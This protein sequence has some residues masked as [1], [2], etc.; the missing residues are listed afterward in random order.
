MATIIGTIQDNVLFGMAE[1]DVLIGGTGNDFYYVGGGD[2][3]VE[4]AN[5]GTDLVVSDVTWALGANLEY[6]TLIGTG[7]V[8]GTGNSLNN[9]LRGNSG[10]NVLIGG[11]GNDTYLCGRGQYGGGTGQ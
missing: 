1:G 3:V 4:N 9:T 8:N 5:E 11:A 2:T 7:A 10:A 6:L